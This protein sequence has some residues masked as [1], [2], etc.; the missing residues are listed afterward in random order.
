[1]QNKEQTAVQKRRLNK[2][3]PR[4][5][6]CCLLKI[7]LNFS[8]RESKPLKDCFNLLCSF[9]FPLLFLVIPSPPP[10]TAFWLPFPHLLSC[11][12]SLSHKHFIKKSFFFR[13]SSEPSI[14]FILFIF[15]PV[16]QMIA[17]SETVSNCSASFLLRPFFHSPTGNQ[18]LC[19]PQYYHYAGYNTPSLRYSSLTFFHRVDGPLQFPSI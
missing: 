9:S 2:T 4:E 10:H 16:G 8:K 18:I 5:K 1:M 19:C 13:L 3:K 12:F 15:T 14:G 11:I 6:Q 7:F 17:S